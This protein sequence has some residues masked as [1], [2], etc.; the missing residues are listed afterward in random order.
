MAIAHIDTLL[1]EKALVLQH[2]GD[3]E[4]AQRLYHQALVYNPF[5]VP[6]PAFYCFL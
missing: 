6:F 1:Y 4:H 2:E 5:H 3:D